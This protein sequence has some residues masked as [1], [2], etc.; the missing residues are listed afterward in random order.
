MSKGAKIRGPALMQ[1]LIDC[2]DTTYCIIYK[3]SIIVDETET[4][5]IPG[6][7]VSFYWPEDSPNASV[8]Q[9]I[10][11]VVDKDEE[12]LHELMMKRVEEDKRKGKSKKSVQKKEQLAPRKKPTSLYDAEIL[13]EL[14]QSHTRN[15]IAKNDSNEKTHPMTA[16]N[17]WLI[18]AVDGIKRQVIST[19]E[20]KFEILKNALLAQSTGTR[21]MPDKLQSQPSASCSTERSDEEKDNGSSQVQITNPCQPIEDDRGLMSPNRQLTQ[22]NLDI[23]NSPGQDEARDVDNHDGSIGN[24]PS[25][26]QRSTRQGNEREGASENEDHMS[27]GDDFLNKT[28]HSNS[29]T[30]S[31]EDAQQPNNSS[32]EIGTP[33]KKKDSTIVTICLDSDDSPIKKNSREPTLVG[34]DK[35]PSV[36]PIL[37][38]KNRFG[39]R[40]LTKK[41]DQDERKKSSVTLKRNRDRKTSESSESGHKR[42]KC[43][44]GTSKEDSYL[45]ES[46]DEDEDKRSK[47]TL[48]FPDNKSRE[49]KELKR[50]TNVFLRVADY[51]AAIDRCSKATEL[52]RQLFRGVFTR[53]ALSKCSLTGS[54]AKGLGKNST[55]ETRPGLNQNAV[56]TII[57]FARDHAK[58]Q[59][60]VKQ[61]VQ[62]IKASLQSFLQ[63]KKASAKLRLKIKAEPDSQK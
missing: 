34:D 8:Y 37:T 39:A 32:F 23:N 60:W 24:S 27:D 17:D 4:K 19:I 51:D 29:I 33:P 49:L 3:K 36:S 25:L 6:V 58:T 43:E 54:K 44:P 16:D 52:A 5:L 1:Y 9:G 31:Q 55:S 26:S 30:N 7:T 57:S 10:I 40:A 61:P 50:K 15:E 35:S 53:D 48:K 45:S 2:R 13:H 11:L 62:M 28:G 59:G 41:N 63:E 46:D 14:N 12:K 56:N 20:E 18:D 47:W 38:S 22:S 42:V 21:S